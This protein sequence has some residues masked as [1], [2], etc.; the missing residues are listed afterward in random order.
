MGKNWLIIKIE[1]AVIIENYNND[2]ND[3]DDNNDDKNDKHNDA[4]DNGCGLEH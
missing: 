3:D 4:D 1:A 2:N